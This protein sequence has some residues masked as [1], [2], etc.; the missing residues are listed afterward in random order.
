MQAMTPITPLEAGGEMFT[1]A[2]TPSLLLPR[3]SQARPI[4]E[5]TEIF[6]TDV[7]DGSE[8]EESGQSQD[9][10]YQPPSPKGSFESVCAS[11]DSTSTCRQ[12]SLASVIYSR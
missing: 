10:A 1:R 3:T 9:E 11:S 8:F 12:P 2:K 6:D 5:A 7:E 4:S